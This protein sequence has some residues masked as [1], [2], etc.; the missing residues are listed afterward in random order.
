MIQPALIND[1]IWIM[2]VTEGVLK[3]KRDFIPAVRNFNGLIHV[4]VRQ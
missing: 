1:F 2:G 4:M 3:A